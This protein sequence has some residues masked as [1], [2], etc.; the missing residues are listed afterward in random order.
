MRWLLALLGGDMGIALC[1]SQQSIGQQA[2]E[3]ADQTAIIAEF[4]RRAPATIQLAFMASR[5]RKRS[6]HSA[7][8]PRRAQRSF[9]LGAC[10]EP[11]HQRVW[12]GDSQFCAGDFVCLSVLGL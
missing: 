6:W 4:A 11:G 12:D 5:S 7:G 3:N 10:I 8:H 1:R 2:C 9:S